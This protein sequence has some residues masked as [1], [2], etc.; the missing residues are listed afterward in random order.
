MCYCPIKIRNPRLDFDPFKDPIYLEVPCGHCSECRQQR[1]NDWLVRAYYETMFTK[2]TGGRTYFI[3]LTYNDPHLPHNSHGNPTF[4][5]DDISLYFKRVKNEFKVRNI[6]T[7]IKY[8]VSFEYGGTTYRPHMHCLVHVPGYCSPYTV[9]H[10]LEDCWTH[11]KDKYFSNY[12]QNYQNNGFVKFGDNGGVVNGHG[13]IKY[14]TKYMCKDFVFAEKNTDEF[15]TYDKIPSPSVS[16]GYGLY[17]LK[18]MDKDD[19]ENAT[20]TMP[21]VKDH[22]TGKPKKFRLPIYLARKLYYD[23]EFYNRSVYVSDNETKLIKGKRY[24]LNDTGKQL[25]VN[26]LDTII[27]QLNKFLDILS[28]NN[29]G[30]DC[31][32][33]DS[34]YSNNEFIMLLNS[35]VTKSFQSFAHFQMYCLNLLGDRDWSMFCDYVLNKQNYFM[36]DDETE[37]FSSDFRSNYIDNLY[38]PRDKY[39]ISV[40][41]Q[42]WEDLK[43]VQE[44][45]CFNGHNDYK[46]FDYLHN[47]FKAFILVNGVLNERL[48]RKQLDIYN[49]FKKLRSLCVKIPYS[50]QELDNSPIKLFNY[51]SFQQN[52]ITNSPV[53][54]SA[55]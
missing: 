17:A 29:G 51:D 33:K 27:E 19:F 11:Y 55:F 32:N 50:H 53:R 41:D 47:M 3:T 37:H 10:I 4:N 21:E 13:A 16:I 24:V 2:D 43:F 34:H 39:N 8:L 31:I 54:R 36:V 25:K 35:C 26:K 18:F 6:Y 46:N 38:S 52:Q 15:G 30:Y 5:K 1:R 44:F 14:V 7:D 28:Q 40:Y 48:L 45:E 22:E 49:A 23:E 12:L 42:S 20:I 9:R